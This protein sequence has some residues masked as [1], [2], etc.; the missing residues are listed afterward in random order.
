M[1]LNL[2]IYLCIAVPLLLFGMAWRRQ[3]RPEARTLLL[4]TASALLLLLAIVRSLK[5]W[6]LGSDYRP[7][8]YV[9][10]EVNMLVAIVALVYFGVTKRW[11]AAL[12]ALILALDW[13][14]IGAV[15]SVV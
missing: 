3:Y 12:A 11:I 14:Y 15:N 13:L 2:L 1:A 4:P 8:L 10:I 6:L 5:V 7:R 9:S